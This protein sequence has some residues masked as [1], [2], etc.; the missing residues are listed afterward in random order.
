MEPLFGGDA[1]AFGPA[2]TPMQARARRHRDDFAAMGAWVDPAAA[3]KAA[4]QAEAEDKAFALLKAWLSPEQIAQLEREACFD[5][6]GSKTGKRYRIHLGRVQ[7]V[8]ELDRKGHP[9]RGW[10]FTPQLYLPMGD[11][12]LAQ[13]IALETDEKGAMKVARPFWKKAESRLMAWLRAIW[14]G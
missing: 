10:C 9:I 13:K 11:V 12:M 2:I 1:F 5:V 8:Y 7:N 3:D 6:T 14:G 4:R